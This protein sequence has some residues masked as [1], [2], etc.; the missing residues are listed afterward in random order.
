[1]KQFFKLSTAMLFL[2]AMALVV[3]SLFSI[4]PL[5]TVPA[6]SSLALVQIPAGSLGLNSTNNISARDSF[7]RARMMFAKAMLDKFNGN[8][9]AAI[10]WANSLK[11]SQGDIRSEVQITTGG[12]N[13]TFGLTT[14]HNS[15]GATG[16]FNTEVPLNQQDSL[17]V[18]EYAIMMRNPASATS[19]IDQ[20]RTYAGATAF[21]TANVITA[22][23]GTFFGSGNFRITCNNDVVVPNRALINHYYVPQTQ[24]GVGITAQT[25]FPLD[26]VRGAEDGFIT[27]EPNIVL[28]GSKNYLP[29]IILPVAMAAVETNMRAVLILRGI[30]AQNSTIIN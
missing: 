20:P 22:V 6:F 16:K 27:A 15:T 29:T 18:T 21:P 17:C 26:Q 19:T 23:N 25:V 1:M 9:Q 10:R 28:I 13:F 14:A 8:L 11:L 2:S 3:S 24:N 4:D 30:L 5:L 7:E 12:T